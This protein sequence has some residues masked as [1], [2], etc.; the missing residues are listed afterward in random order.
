M[1][2]I[3]IPYKYH[4]LAFCNSEKTSGINLVFPLSEFLAEIKTCFRD[5]HIINTRYKQRNHIKSHIFLDTTCRIQHVRSSLQKCQRSS[6]DGSSER[7]SLV[8]RSK[9]V[10]KHPEAN[11]KNPLRGNL[12]RS[13]QQDRS[14]AKK[15]MFSWER[16]MALSILGSPELLSAYLFKGRFLLLQWHVDKDVL[17]YDV[18]VTCTLILN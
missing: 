18:T 10:P 6:C 3:S 17:T 14:M 8:A 7:D 1:F 4:A 15:I 12:P 2:S 11:D 5:H 16:S 13:V 9:T